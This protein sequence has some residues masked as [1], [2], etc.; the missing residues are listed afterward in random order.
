MAPYI[1]SKLVSDKC[2]DFYA[3]SDFVLK[4]QSFHKQ[5][6]V[7]WRVMF[8]PDTIACPS[9]ACSLVLQILLF[10]TMTENPTA[11]PSWPAETISL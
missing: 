4:L 6:M 10:I 9:L 3:F 11:F 5:G 2:Q 1:Y 8:S 7:L